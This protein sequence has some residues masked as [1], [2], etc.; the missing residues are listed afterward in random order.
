MAESNGHMPH[1]GGEINVRVLDDKIDMDLVKKVIQ[2]PSVLHESVQNRDPY[3]LV[4]YTVLLVNDFHNYYSSVNILGSD[5]YIAK[6]RV[7][8]VE[9]VRIIPCD[10]NGSPQDQTT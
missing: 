2:F 7:V 8:L 6:A 10:N 3:A 1:K 5:A 9:A 4:Y